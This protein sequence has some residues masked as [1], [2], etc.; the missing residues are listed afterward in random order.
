MVG[1]VDMPLLLENT[2]TTALPLPLIKS[3]SRHP[4]DFQPQLL[5]LAK[6]MGLIW[7]VPIPPAMIV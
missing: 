5:A 4:S 7:H 6:H 2:P 1:I 3:G